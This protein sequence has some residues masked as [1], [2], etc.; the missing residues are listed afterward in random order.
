GIGADVARQHS[1]GDLP[2]PHPPQAVCFSGASVS[3]TTRCLCMAPPLLR[4]V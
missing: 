1:P 2:R 3:S 4:M